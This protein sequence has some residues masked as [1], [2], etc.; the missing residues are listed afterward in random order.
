MRREG[1]PIGPVPAAAILAILLALSLA[2]LQRARL[3]PGREQ[4]YASCTVTI[5]NAGVDSRGIERTIT[6]PLEDAL[7]S[8]PG[9]VQLR[10]VSEY[11]RSRVTVIAAP[12]EG[13][14]ALSPG[15]RDAVERVAAGLPS[16]AQKPRIVASALG[17]RPVFIAA[18]RS[19]GGNAEDLRDRVERGVKP[20]FS[21]VAGAGEVDA[22]GGAAREVHVRVDTAKA[23]LHGL[24]TAAVAGQIARQALLAPAGTFTRAGS[25]MTASATGR[26]SSIPDLEALRVRFLAGAARPS[27]RSR[28]WSTVCA[29]GRASAGWTAAKPW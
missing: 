6:V 17:H 11:G 22:G 20:R 3:G 27:R 19:A 18:V 13:R 29:R 1:W 14:A 12:G 21:Q 5:E 8:V 4:G 28:R 15:I 16:S 23:A 26:P 7:A 9:V 25:R 2:F 24:S 10:S